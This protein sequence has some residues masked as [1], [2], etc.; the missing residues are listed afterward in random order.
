MTIDATPA[1]RCQFYLNSLHSLL[2][3]TPDLD[4]NL[5]AHGVDDPMAGY[6]AARTA[7]LGPVGPGAVTAVTNGFH[8]RLIAGHFP[9]LWDRV[10][11]A[12][13]IAERLRAADTTLRRCLGEEIAEA[14]ETAEAAELALRAAEGCERAG[15]PMYAAHTDLPVPDQPHLALWHAATLLRE[16]RGDGH[17]AVL[18]HAGLAG[19]DGL[20]SHSAGPGGMPR[21]FVMTKRGWTDEDWTAA[22][23]RLRNRGLL[24]AAGALTARGLELRAQVERDTDRLDAAP[25]AHLGAEGV[26]RLTTLCRRLVT[27]AAGTGVF[28]A[29]L[30]PVFADA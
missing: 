4:E 18:T 1:N 14:P 13:V 8:H 15:R 22:E 11:P 5:A 3:F 29:P 21:A 16:Y 27:T 10:A 28:P 17:F 6:F 26:A 24:D 7:A 9:A 25:Y 12:K 20:V 19:L 30:L 23:E 2:Y